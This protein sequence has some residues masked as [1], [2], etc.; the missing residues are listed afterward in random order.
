MIKKRLIEILS[1][2]WSEI[3]P[4]VNIKNSFVVKEP[5]K[6]I[7]ADYASNICFQGSKIIKTS[8]IK[9]AEEFI[10]KLESSE[11]K[12]IISKV[13]IAGPG[14]LNFVLNREVFCSEI[15]RVFTL[16]K[17]FDL[18]IGDGQ[19]V[20]I[21]FVSANPT[22]PLH[23][24]HAR[25]AAIGDSLARVL[26]K[27]GFA[28]DK[29]YYV[30]DAGNQIDVL[31]KSLEIRYKQLLGEKIDLPDGYYHGDYITD[32]AKKLLSLD[33][34]DLGLDFRKI[35]LDEMVL[36]IK[37]DLK[38]FNIEFDNWFFESSIFEKN[39]ENQSKLD[40][41]IE[42]LKSRNYIKNVDGAWWLMTNDFGD[43]DKNRVI[44]RN[45]GRPTYFAT[46]IAYHKNKLDRGY[47]YLVDIWGADHHGYVARLKASI[48][49]LGNNPGKIKI[50]LYHLVS[51]LRGGE[52]VAMSTRSGEFISLEEVIEEVGSDATRFSLL[53]RDGNSP[54]D[55][56]LELAKKKT[57]ENPVYYVQYAHA[58]INSILKN[59]KNEKINTDFSE[60]NL[61]FL[62]QNLSE[63]EDLI[64]MKAILNYA[65]VLVLC[66]K[67][68]SSHHI[69]GY[70]LDLAGKFHNY[71]AKHKIVDKENQNLTRTRLFICELL[72]QVFKDALELLGIS[73]PE[74]M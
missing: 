12:K 65:D 28:V 19:K 50:I 17:Y 54:L 45:D 7:D 38:K 31:G 48:E 70:L 11:S 34:K 49:Y 41:A 27:V 72:R 1:E 10:K 32:V 62:S 64:L 30:N 35:I 26:K 24:G 16:K 63:K 55:F 14:F 3:Y 46:D 18:N 58:R 15:L 25:G 39:V 67:E 2:V 56:D 13:F 60:I 66:A 52:K 73:A 9:V 40:E 69:T 37:N 57:N 4:E 20:L 22:G 53:M 59:A 6:N 68:F 51:L 33:K 43:D 71:Y 5:P 42:V 36:V 44:I 23:I 47:D 74:S 29:E 21:E 8:P 61:D